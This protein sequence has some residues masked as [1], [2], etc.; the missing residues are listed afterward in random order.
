MH[1][2][3]NEWGIEDGNHLGSQSD[4]GKDLFDKVAL[5]S[6]Q[7]SGKKNTYLR[8]S[9]RKNL[10]PGGDLDSRD[11]LVIEKMSAR[12]QQQAKLTEANIKMFNAIQ[13]N[14]MIVYF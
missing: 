10:R 13:K 1:R 12:E 6:V 9:V 14:N 5:Q 2:D 8:S 11:T 3:L 4:M 7:D